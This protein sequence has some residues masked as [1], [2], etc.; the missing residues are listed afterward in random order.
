VPVRTNA[1]S[2]ES[3]LFANVGVFIAH[4]IGIMVRVYSSY[5]AMK[6]FSTAGALTAT[7]GIFLGLRFVYYLAFTSEGNLH[8]QS[9]I[10]AAI[11]LIAGFQMVLTGIVADLIN[12]CRGVLEDVSY[13]VRRLELERLESER[14]GEDQRLDGDIELIR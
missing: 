2:R 13:R 10:L 9:L 1:K 5:R 14:L 4:S 7:V 3:R 11:L 8:T 12:S 6:I